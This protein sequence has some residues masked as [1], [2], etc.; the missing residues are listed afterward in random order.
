[1]R[2][3]QLYVVRTARVGRTV[4]LNRLSLREKSQRS[5]EP[6]GM[7]GEPGND[8]RLCEYAVLCVLICC[9]SGECAVVAHAA[10][11]RMSTATRQQTC[12]LLGTSTQLTLR[13]RYAQAAGE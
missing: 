8:R 4:L 10:R 7:V 3:A 11:S 1:M 2:C 13:V 6:A 12:A 9:F 5:G